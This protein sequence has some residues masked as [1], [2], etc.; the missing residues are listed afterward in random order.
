MPFKDFDFC[1]KH[2][3]QD[4]ITFGKYSGRTVRD[5]IIKDVGWITWAYYNRDMAFNLSETAFDAMVYMIN[6]NGGHDSLRPN[7]TN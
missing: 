3:L 5:I 1:Y 2:K 4:H 6:K 7:T